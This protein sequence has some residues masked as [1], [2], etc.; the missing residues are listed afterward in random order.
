M[1]MKGSTGQDVSNPLLSELRQLHL[2]VNLT[3]SRIKTDVPESPGII[4]VVGGVNHQCTGAN[5]RWVG[6]PDAST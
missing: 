1:D 6:R 4:G 2:A 3:L 5:R